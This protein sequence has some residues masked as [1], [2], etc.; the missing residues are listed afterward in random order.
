MKIA[1]PL[2]IA[3][4]KS[5]RGERDPDGRREHREEGVD[6]VHEHVEVQHDHERE[7]DAAV[8]SQAGREKAADAA[9]PI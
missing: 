7:P 4:R 1:E 5:D 3:R 2:L 9:P 6:A 8:E